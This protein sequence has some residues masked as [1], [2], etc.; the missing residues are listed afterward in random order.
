MW[1]PSETVF[2]QQ[3]DD[4]NEFR[5]DAISSETIT[6]E[7]R[8]IN[9]LSTSEYDVMD[10]TIY[11]NFF[12][13]LKAKVNVDRVQASKGIHVVTSDLLSQKWLISP[14]ASRITVHQTTQQGI[15]TILHPSLS[16]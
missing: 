16:R 10:L 12:N 8:I 14:E 11:D 1:E 9:S 3:E 13:T 6:R 2:P 5:G 7:R 4:I 15:R